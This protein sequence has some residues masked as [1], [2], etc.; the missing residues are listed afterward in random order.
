MN[1]LGMFGGLDGERLAVQYVR[2]AYHQSRS[3]TRAPRAFT[4]QCHIGNCRPGASCAVT[5]KVFIAKDQ[6]SKG[7]RRIRNCP[8]D[9]LNISCVHRFR[10]F[11]STDSRPDSYGAAAYCRRSCVRKACGKPP[12]EKHR[13]G[14]H[15]GPAIA[16]ASRFWLLLL[17]PIA[18]LRES[19]GARWGSIQSDN[20]ERR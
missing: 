12:T 11:R 1:A 10:T 15:F 2:A 3:P 4:S 13:W 18:M 5:S 17:L 16:G 7:K 8:G 14:H 19:I 20:A 6:L 9:R